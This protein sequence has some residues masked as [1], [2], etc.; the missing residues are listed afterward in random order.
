MKRR[1]FFL[2]LSALLA[3]SWLPG[4][5]KAAAPFGLRRVSG[6][7]PLCICP[8]GTIRAVVCNDP[9]VWFEIMGKHEAECAVQGMVKH[10][11]SQ[12]YHLMPGS[13][14]SRQLIVKLESQEKTTR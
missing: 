11:E 13:D 8:A 9:D 10:W 1:S 3:G 6:I 2:G 5:A 7:R 4:R 14:Y 12:G